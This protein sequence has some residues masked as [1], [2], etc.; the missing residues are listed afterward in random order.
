MMNDRSFDL[1]S[2]VEVLERT[3]RVV[4][5]MLD[6]LSDD[7]TSGGG[8]D[9]WGPIDVVGHLIHG[10]KTDWIPRAEIILEHGE[11]RTFTPFDRLAQFGS[12]RGRS[13][14]ELIAQFETLRAENLETLRSWNLSESQFQLKGMH[15][16]LGKVT[17]EQLIA[18]WL[19]HDL[20]HIRQIATFMARKY[21]KEVGPWKE[22]LSILH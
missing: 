11:E 20:T 4:R 6:G 10:E 5:A 1:E 9:D 19:V 14:A 17:L 22:Y 16:E 3:P 21:E 2:A 7:W 15:P 18:T 12:S 8:E 13:L